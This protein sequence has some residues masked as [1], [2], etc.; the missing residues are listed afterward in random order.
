MIS[1]QKT[2]VDV[3]RRL[4]GVER[5]AADLLSHIDSFRASHDRDPTFRELRESAYGKKDG[6]TEASVWSYLFELERQGKIDLH[7]SNKQPELT[8]RGH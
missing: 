2:V 7:L 6:P 3:G 8:R 4:N 5:G 1:V